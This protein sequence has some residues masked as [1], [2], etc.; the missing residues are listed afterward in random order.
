ME[1]K[2]A[3]SA[4]APKPDDDE[5]DILEIL[6]FLKSK[7]R[8]LMIFLILG[9]VA[10]GIASM[11]MRP[12]YSSD[13][14]LQVDVKGNKSVKALGEMGALLDAS[15]PSE[16]EMQ[17]LKSRM[18]LASVVEE[19]RICFSA[20]PLNK[21]DR[22]L[23]REGRMDL[24]YLKIPKSVSQAG[25]KIY[26][27]VLADTSSF[28]ILDDDEKVILKGV[29][30]ETY[31]QPYADDS[32]IVCVRSIKATAGQMFQLA[33]IHPQIAVAGLLK[34]LNVAEEGK[35][36][37]IIRV[38]MTHKYSDRVAEILNSVANTYL[39]QNI[40]MRSA[41][42]KK[43][44]EFLEEQL[45]GVKAKLDSAEHKLTSYRHTK[46]TIDLSG[47]TRVHLQKD[48]ELQQ[49]LLEL[50]QKKQEALRLFQAEHP[51]I[52]TIEQQQA[53]L[54]GELAKQQKAA[55]KLPLTQ[56]EVLSLQEEVEVNNRLYTNL[57]NN[58]QQLRVVQAGEVGNVR[59]VDRAYVPIKPSKPNRKLIFLG[60]VF[61]FLL[62][63]CALVLVRRM[64]QN[65]V[66]SSSELELAT[67]IGV[68]GKLPLIGKDTVN[69]VLKPVVHENP[70]EPFAEGIRALRTALEFSLM[71]DKDKVL[72]VTGLVEG[73]G[74]SFVSI[75]LASSFAMS[76]KKVLLVDMDLRRGHMFERS[77]KGLCEMLRTDNYSDEYIEKVFENFHVL[78]SGKRVVNPGDLLGKDRFGKFLDIARNQYDL[79]ILDTP[80]VFQCS[81][82]LLVEK[83]VD[84]IL[85]VLKHA[86]HS[87]ES[88]QDALAMF[89]RSTDKP[90]PKAFVFNKCERNRSGY[91]YG[92]NYGYYHKKY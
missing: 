59:I 12:A 83:Y 81:D 56:Q 45:P 64:T 21:M 25:M 34:S 36:S 62:F 48:V 2:V 57:L 51:T 23:H 17:L 6:V 75:N 68:Y 7:W 92:G 41:E 49:K 77:H 54:R 44:L 27:R 37:G 38:K 39:K 30:G 61:G 43:T 5:I 71:M 52:R 55:A 28:E 29:V 33:A 66:T 58:I 79:I 74:K 91:G 32:L 67:G 69:N 72:M 9:V 47:E 18:V 20:N 14:L 80:P 89:D 22:L 3:Q 19:E 35:N 90:L 60:V 31:R 82:A 88:I 13:I 10:G 26:A 76:G 40:E 42:A 15:S 70:D 78:A 24:E 84:H 73:V 1:N 8:F 50:E 86:S 16:A 4:V 63:G 85:C 65:G 46:G 11:W 87:M 53:K